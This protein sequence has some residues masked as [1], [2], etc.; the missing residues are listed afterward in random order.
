MQ[1]DRNIHLLLDN[2]QT[3]TAPFDS[4]T[5]ALVQLIQYYTKLDIYY[6][7]TCILCVSVYNFE[8]QGTGCVMLHVVCE[9]SLWNG[10]NMNPTL[11]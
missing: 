6:I 1:F 2:Y 5:S 9:K 3:I 10:M 11:Q 4:D 8:I 7:N